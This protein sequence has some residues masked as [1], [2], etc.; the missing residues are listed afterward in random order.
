V[1]GNKTLEEEIRVRIAKGTKTL[2]ANKTLLK[3]N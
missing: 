1:N 3:A 2:Y